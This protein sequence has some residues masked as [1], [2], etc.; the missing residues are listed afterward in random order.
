[1][2]I[3]V[4]IVENMKSRVQD[5]YGSGQYGASRDKG[6]RKH[7]G[8]DIITIVD[9][10]IYCPF[11]ADIIR[12]TFP[13]KGDNSYEGVVIRGKGEWLGYEAK[14][15]YVTGLI[16]GGVTAGQHIAFAQDLTIKYPKITNHLHFEVKLN[17]QQ[18]DPF[19]V[20]Q[21]SF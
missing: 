5:K 20:W 6:E 21:M 2:T 19:E 11:E 1:M 9:E 12:Q 14:I 18:L 8:I 13:Y 7:N 16:S 4:N 3:G 10:K 15:F 17:G